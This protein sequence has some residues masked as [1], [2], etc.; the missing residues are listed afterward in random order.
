VLGL[1]K[2]RTE[3]NAAVERQAEAERQAAQPVETSP[4]AADL[5]D[6][7][8][9]A[10]GANVPS[11]AITALIGELQAAVAWAGEAAAKARGRALDP[12]FAASEVAVAHREMESAAFRGERLQA[13]L[14]RLREHL[15]KVKREEEDQRRWLA[16]QKAEAERDKLAAELADVYP[17]FERNLADLL[18]RIEANDRAIERINAHALPDGAKR[19]HVAE[20][21]ARNVGNFIVD[22]LHQVARITKQ[23]RLPAFKFDKFSPYTWPPRRDTAG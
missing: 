19:L 14:T 21:V 17:Q 12:V 23:L 13:A 5:D 4:P 16:Y 22:G 20:Q 2:L 1:G 6:R 11:G 15:P 3:H 18:T 9:A 8:A 10:V 7:V